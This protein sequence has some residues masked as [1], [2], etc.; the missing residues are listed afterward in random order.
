MTDNT[1]SNSLPTQ[2]GAVNNLI[3]LQLN[4]ITRLDKMLNFIEETAFSEAFIISMLA[5]P[6]TLFSFY[7]LI[8]QNKVMSENFILKLFE[9]SN[10]NQ[11]VGQLISDIVTSEEKIKKDIPTQEGSEKLDEFVRALKAKS[12]KKIHGNNVFSIDQEDTIVKTSEEFIEVVGLPNT[13]DV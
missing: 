10:K 5:T 13:E 3:S 12:L 11:A 1:H 7:N 4:R 2:V 8:H 6:K 9:L